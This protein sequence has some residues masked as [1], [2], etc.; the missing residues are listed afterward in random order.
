MIDIDDLLP[1]VKATLLTAE[2]TERFEAVHTA[3]E[4]TLESG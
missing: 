2:D 1:Q 4:Q 3:Y